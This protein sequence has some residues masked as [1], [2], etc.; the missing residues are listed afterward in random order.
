MKRFTVLSVVVVLFA[1]VALAG[2]VV[3]KDVSA[4]AKWFG[5]VDFD[6]IRA[7]PMVQDLKTKCPEHAR[8]EAKMQ[9]M[10]K[11]L[12]FES[13]DDMQGATLYSNAFGGKQGVVLFY[14][15][16]FDQQ[17][18]IGLLKEKHPDPKTLEYGSHTLYTWTAGHEARKMDVTGAFAGDTVLVMG[19]NVAQVQA[20]LD[21]LDGK[22]PGLTKDSPLVAGLMEKVLFASRALDVPEDYRKTTQCPV[23]HN[24]K[25][26]TAVWTYSDGQIT[27]KYELTADSAEAATN[28]KAVVDG[29]KAMVLLRARDL[30]AVKKMLDA[31]KTEVN[32]EVFT[33]TFS[34]PTADIEAAM[35][36]MMEQRKAAKA[37]ATAPAAQ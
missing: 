26:A 33:A 22:K 10:A 14:A 2:P 20:A 11:K 23:L 1:G 24:C 13:L 32:G 17:K 34:A 16:K 25:A 3:P 15:K 18:M 12:G 28:F 37:A 36:T 9:E 27:G 7:M 19:A 31:A 35:Q 30:P 5:H 4:D 21:V 6:A 8:C 29:F